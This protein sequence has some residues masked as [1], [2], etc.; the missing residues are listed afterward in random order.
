MQF[1]G[2]LGNEPVKLA[3][4]TA[5]D[6][7]RFPHAV[8]LQGEPGTGKRTLAALLANALVCRCPEVTRRPCGECPACIRAKAGSHP[9]IRTVEGSGV[10][11]SL[12][13]E[14][15]RLLS[16]EAYRTP[17]EADCRVF[18][19]QMGTRVQEAA[20]NKLLKLIEEP[21]AT[22]VFVLVAESAELLLPTI[23]SRVQIYTLRPPA[24]EEAAR[25]LIRQRQ[26]EPDR[27]A[28]LAALCNGNLGRMQEE[29]TGGD[30]ARAQEIASAMGQALLSPYGDPLFQAAAPLQKDKKLLGEVLTR[31]TVLLRDALALGLGG[32]EQ[33]LLSGAGELADRLSRFSPAQLMELLAVVEETAQR[34]E[35]NANMA[36]LTTDLCL[37]LRAAAGR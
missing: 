20:Q 35:R 6:A 11:K 26:A 5:F 10:T 7:G 2:F 8:A 23:R 9:D 34:L 28:Q 1:P 22:A 27:A 18:L 17:E 15:V 25:W 16:E 31:L 36:L 4:S 14:A 12:T 19:L 30:L 21:P 37:R 32:P 33:T 29:F 3:L 24:V 13:V